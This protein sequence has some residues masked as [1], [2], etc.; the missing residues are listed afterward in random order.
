M[1]AHV[2]RVKTFRMNGLLSPK[3]RIQQSF[4][5]KVKYIMLTLPCYHIRNLYH[6]VDLRLGENALA[7]RALN[8]EAKNPERRE[9]RPLS[10]GRM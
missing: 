5:P 9:C 2:L 1:C 7:A 4:F 10:F 3:P 8:V 6:R